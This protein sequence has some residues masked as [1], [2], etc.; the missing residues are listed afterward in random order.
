M[1]GH[2]VLL[3]R[4]AELARLGD[5]LDAAGAGEGGLV[6]V[7]GAPGAGK[8]SLL[9]AAADEARDRD[10]EVARARGAELEREWPFGIARQLLEPVLRR[11]S[12]EERAELLEGAAGLATHVVLPELADAAA[13]VDVSFGALHGLYWLT[14]NLATRRPLLLAVDDAQWADDA[15]SASS[16]CWRGGSRGC[17]SWSCSRSARRRTCSPSSWPTPRPSTCALQPLSAA[18]VER[19]LQSC[20]PGP[21]DPDSRRRARPRPAVTRFS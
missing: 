8:T 18:A 21:V 9:R 7:E 3:E 1:V 13:P 20:S 4:E 14:A 11:R 19:F 15:R 10:F 5:R 16:A 12:A 6:I 2:V 17:P